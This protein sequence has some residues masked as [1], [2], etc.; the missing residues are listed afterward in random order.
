MQHAPCV[1]RI[2]QKAQLGS[3]TGL[4]QSILT[5]IAVQHEEEERWD[6]DWV[7]YCEY[8]GCSGITGPFRC[9]HTLDTSAANE[10]LQLKHYRQQKRTG[11]A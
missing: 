9:V 2:V 3:D 5:L 6:T 1:E 7:E 11:M 10:T 8:G 4:L